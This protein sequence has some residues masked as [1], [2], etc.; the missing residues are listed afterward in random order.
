M[1]QARE[2]RDKAR[3]RVAIESNPSDVR[4]VKKAAKL[5]NEN[6]FEVVAREWYGKFSANCAPIHTLKNRLEND[7]FL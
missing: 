4:K 6:T 7:V 1:G 3:K 2:Q 5:E